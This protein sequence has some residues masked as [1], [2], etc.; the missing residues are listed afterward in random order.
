MFQYDFGP[1]KHALELRDYVKYIFSPCIFTLHIMILMILMAFT[2]TY[3]PKIKIAHGTTKGG[4]AEPVSSKRL[5]KKSLFLTTPLLK[6]F[7]VAILW[8]KHC[9]IQTPAAPDRC[10]EKA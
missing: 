2:A 5:L 3:G 10:L 8:L 4:V 1:P 6:F 9:H 7:P